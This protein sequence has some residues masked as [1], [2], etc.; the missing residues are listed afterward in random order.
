MSVPAVI[1]P[2][3]PRERLFVEEYVIDWNGTQA[4]IRAG[5]SPRSAYVIASQLLNRPQVQLAVQALLEERV[6]RIRATRDT[7]EQNLAAWLISDANEVI[8]VRRICCRFCHGADN[9]YQEKPSEHRARLKQH[10]LTRIAAGDDWHKLG[11]FDELGGVGYDPRKPP[12][13]DCPECFGEGI[14]HVHIA[15]TRKLSKA[16]AMSYAGLKVTTAGIEVK[17]QDKVKALEMIGR[18]LGMFGGADPDADASVRTIRLI[19]DP[20]A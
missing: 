6:Q 11:P 12:N 3:S 13:D 15:D 10:D 19:N 17:L 16:A 8:Q 4:A 14:E 5:Y 9:L 7:V 20:D 18:N 1:R 2:L